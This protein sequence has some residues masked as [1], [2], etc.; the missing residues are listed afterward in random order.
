MSKFE[1]HLAAMAFHQAEGI[2]LARGAG[3]EQRSKVAPVDIEALTTSEEDCS[4]YPRIRCAFIFAPGHGTRLDADISTP[5]FGF[6][7]QLP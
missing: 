5:G 4:T 7:A 3:I 1:I 2:E 6:R